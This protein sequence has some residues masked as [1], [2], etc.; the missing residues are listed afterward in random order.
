MANSND[1][2][3]LGSSSGLMGIFSSCSDTHNV[4]DPQGEIR[5]VYVADGQ[6]VGEAIENAQFTDQDLYEQSKKD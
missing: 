5:E 4:R 6:D 2:E 3:D 1:W